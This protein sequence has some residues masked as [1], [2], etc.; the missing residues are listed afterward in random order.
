MQE[1][2]VKQF[3]GELKMQPEH[4]L[5]QLKSAGVNKTSI[6][7]A[8]SHADKERLLDFL[9][10]GRNEGGRVTL[11]R[12]ETSEV[13]ANDASGRSRTI[14][15]EVRKKRVLVKRDPAELRAEALKAAGASATPAEPVAMVSPPFVSSLAYIQLYGRRGWITYRLLH[16]ALWPL[17][18]TQ[19][20]NQ[21]GNQ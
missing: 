3:A 11:K 21:S 18:A 5:E 16:A 1:M 19:A 4:L 20:K 9:R 2:N 8:L 12:K 6:N 10:Q 15:V 7:D 14:Q 13:R 17:H